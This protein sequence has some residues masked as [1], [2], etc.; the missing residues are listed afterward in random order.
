MGKNGE[1]L[2]RVPMLRNVTKT[3]PYFHSGAIA[4]IREAVYLMGK[5]QLGMNLTDKQIDEIVA[6]LKSLEGDIVD[7]NIQKGEL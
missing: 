7:Y 1:R 5:H 4:K 6:F 2:F 3:S